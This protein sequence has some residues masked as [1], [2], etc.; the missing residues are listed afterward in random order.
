MVSTALVSTIGIQPHRQE[1]LSPMVLRLTADPN[2][3]Q[4]FALCTYR[5]NGSAVVTPVWMAGM[6]GRWYAYTP[7]RSGKVRRIG[8]NPTV[9]MASSDFHGEPY[10]PWRPGHARILSG[11]Q[12]RPARRALTAK[13]GLKFRAARLLMFLSQTRRRSGPPLVLEI[14]LDDGAV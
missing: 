6:A 11:E 2:G 7:S 8:R 9:A 4:F 12:A 3:D 5:R 13:Y 1:R 14:I 10:E